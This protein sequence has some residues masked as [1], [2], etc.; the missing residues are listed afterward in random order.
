MRTQ[1]ILER[2]QWLKPNRK[3]IASDT[4]VYDLVV[5]LTV[6]K[7]NTVDEIL[8]MIRRQS[9][10]G[11]YRVAM[12]V[13]QNGEHV[14]ITTPLS[15]WNRA[16]QWGGNRVDILHIWNTVETGYYGRFLSPLA[17]RYSQGAKFIVLDDDVMFGRRYFENLL[18][19]VAEGSL[20]TRNGR[21]L[22]KQLQEFDWRGYWKESDVDTFD[23]DDV[24]DFG[25][26]IWAGK[27]AWLRTAWQHPPPILYSAEDFWLSAVLKRELG[28]PTK[29][30]CCPAPKSHGDVELCACSM[31]IANDHISAKVGNSDVNE[32]R[33]TRSE[34]MKII[35]AHYGFQTVLSKDP[36][37]AERMGKRHS[38]IPI[39]LFSPSNQTKNMFAQCLY[40]Y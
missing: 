31:K 13:F 15:Q 7:R 2:S 12:V 23:E 14:N 28:I 25:G 6:W 20:A 27:I 34:A 10:L 24:Y 9:I 4:F 18:R 22:G 1:K 29:R 26:H 32:H 39:D 35:A 37:A 38:E 11:E 30:P 33:E 40:W 36:M 17:V 5:V 21:F 19:A 16:A 3:P 8:K